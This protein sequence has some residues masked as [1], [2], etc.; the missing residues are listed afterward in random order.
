MLYN[1]YFIWVG[2]CDFVRKGSMIIL[3]YKE[4]GYME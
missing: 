3:F 1:I 4:Y 2:I